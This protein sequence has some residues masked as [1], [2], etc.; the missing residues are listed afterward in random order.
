MQSNQFSYKNRFLRNFFQRRSNKA[1][2]GLSNHAQFVDGG[3]SPLP[4]ILGQIDASPKNDQLRID[5]SS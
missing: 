5:I 3:R 1:F 4:E 2:A